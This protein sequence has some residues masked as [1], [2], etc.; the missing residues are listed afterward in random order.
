MKQTTA[1][2]LTI[3]FR[4]GILLL[5]T[6]LLL[7]LFAKTSQAQDSAAAEKVS[8]TIDFVC[9]QKGDNSVDLKATYKAKI[10]GGFLKLSEL[11]I[12]F[13]ATTDSA[14]KKLG[15]SYTD[16]NGVALL[17]CKAEDVIADKEGKI[18]FKT[19]FA[20]DAKT[21]AAEEVVAATRAKL[22][23]TAVKVDSALSVQVKLVDLSTGTEKA[24]PETDLAVFVKRLFYPL[25]V[26]EGKT[27]SSGMIAVDIPN[28]LPGDAKGNIV[29]M[30]KLDDNETYGNLEASV[31]QQWGIPV[32]DEV[33]ELPRALWSPHP[34]MW[35]LI[36][37]IIL[38]SVVWGHYIVIVYELF[39]LRKEEKQ[40][41]GTTEG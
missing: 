28:D 23:I 10:K 6:L 7:N 37:F 14:E 39:R 40:P 21:E 38:I 17:N 3:K 29:L 4:Q 26:G 35:M 19:S 30:A 34:P 20:G 41:V 27:D 31:T 11:K 15:S 24:I 32:S 2:P 8:P 5:T 9:I 13:F 18:H 25:K 22:I 33:K 1:I 12:D 36:T 16:H